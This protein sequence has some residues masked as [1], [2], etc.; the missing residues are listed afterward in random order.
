MTSTTAPVAPV[1]DPGLSGRVGSGL[2]RVVPAAIAALLVL[3]LWELIVRVFEIRPIL[4]PA[5]AAILGTFLDDLPRLAEAVW[6][7]GRAALL[8]FLVG[9]LAGFV[10]GAL[11]AGWAWLREG[12]L[13]VGVALGA[14]P[15]VATA[16]IFNLWFGALSVWSNAAVVALVVFFPMLVNTITGLNAAETGHTEL[17]RSLA[18]NRRTVFVKLLLPT[19]LPFVFGA[20]R[21]GAA[22]AVIAAVVADFFGGFRS[23]AGFFIKTLMATADY[24]GAWATVLALCLFG[25]ALYGTVASLERWMV[26]TAT[27]S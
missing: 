26:P 20:L 6:T 25:L 2:R 27:E 4:L 13:P 14:I 24:T 23:S 22:L 12:M 21:V 9:G 16:P 1:A 8:G 15:I 11:V 19:A 5:P 18:A 10:A 17:M 7:T 3:A